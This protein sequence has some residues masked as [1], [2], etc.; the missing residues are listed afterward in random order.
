MSASPQTVYLYG[1][2]GEPGRRGPIGKEGAPGPQGPAGQPGPPG[3]DGADGED[4]RDA[5]TLLP[6]TAQFIRD[7]EDR[8]EVVIVRGDSGSELRIV[9]TYNGPF[10]AGGR[11]E[12]VRPPAGT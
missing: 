3:Q 8:V 4:G 11:L 5:I 9:P 6:G 2:E 10:I 12:I 1:P 7:A